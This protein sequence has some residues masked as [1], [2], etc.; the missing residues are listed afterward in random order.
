MSPLGLN[1]PCSTKA[2]S[3]IDE[4]PGPTSREKANVFTHKKQVNLS[5]IIS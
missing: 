5:T 4:Q 1:G 2:P 3:P